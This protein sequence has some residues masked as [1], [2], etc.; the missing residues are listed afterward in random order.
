MT[1]SLLPTSLLLLLAASAPHRASALSSHSP[2]DLYAFPRYQVSLGQDGVLNETV[3]ELLAAAVAGS[4]DD[5]GDEVSCSVLNYIDE[6]ADR[7][8][9]CT[10]HQ[11]Q[12]HATTSRRTAS[13]PDARRPSLPLHSPCSKPYL[14]RCSSGRRHRRVEL[15]RRCE[16]S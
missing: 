6:R 12:G 8:T 7:V 1:L 10:A 3:A 4:E 11:Q 9:W 14:S 13:P 5:D 2:T 16:R 15:R